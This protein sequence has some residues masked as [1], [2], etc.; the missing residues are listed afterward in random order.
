MG[1]NVN[2]TNNLA[3]VVGLV[4]QKHPDSSVQIEWREGTPEQEWLITATDG[5]T[6]HE[7]VADDESGSWA[8]LSATDRLVLEAGGSILAS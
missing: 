7:Y 6:D 1:T 3:M 4:A 8:P 2:I 5:V